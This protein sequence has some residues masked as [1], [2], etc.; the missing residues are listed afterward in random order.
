MADFY[1][2]C[3]VELKLIKKSMCE[4]VFI[5]SFSGPYSGQ[6]RENM[7][8]ENSEYGHFSRSE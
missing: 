5:R 8:N 4:K 6:F 3:N 7:D 2:K 1:M